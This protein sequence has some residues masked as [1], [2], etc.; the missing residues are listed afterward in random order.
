MIIPSL[1]VGAKPGVTHVLYMDVLVGPTWRRLD[2]VELWDAAEVWESVDRLR[3]YGDQFEGGARLLPQLVDK[4]IQ[5]KAIG[6]DRAGHSEAM[7]IQR[8]NGLADQ[9]TQVEA[10][11]REVRADRDELR[12]EVARLKGRTR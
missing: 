2:E 11:L 5:L 3:P 12:E 7:A 8:A 6:M 4:F 10:K 9:L 1:P